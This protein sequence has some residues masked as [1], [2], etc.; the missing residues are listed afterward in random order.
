MYVIMLVLKSASSFMLIKGVLLETLARLN[1]VNG[2][3]LLKSISSSKLIVSFVTFSKLKVVYGNEALKSMSSC[4]PIVSLV[5][6]SSVK[7]LLM[8]KSI[9]MQVIAPVSSI[10]S[11]VA[12]EPQLDSSKKSEPSSSYKSVVKISAAVSISASTVPEKLPSSH[13]WEPFPIS[14]MSS[15]EGNKLPLMFN[16]VISKLDRLPKK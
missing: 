12:V 9:A 6:F 5:T 3:E 4:C 10:V 13:C 1:V 8:G 14:K 15:K 16:V 2:S 7:A 11:K